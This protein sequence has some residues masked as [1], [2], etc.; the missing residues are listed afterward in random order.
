MQQAGGT[1]YRFLSKEITNKWCFPAE[2]KEII[3]SESFPL[4]MIFRVCRMD[5]GQEGRKT[6]EWLRKQA[7]GDEGQPGLVTQGGLSQREMRTGNHR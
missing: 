1:L 3:P 7:W 2:M 6:Q 5:W 4:E